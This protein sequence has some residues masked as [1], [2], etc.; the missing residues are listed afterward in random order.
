MNL[1]YFPFTQNTG[2]FNM[3]ADEYLV[4]NKRPSLRLYGWGPPCL[5]LGY[6]QSS[7]DIDHDVLKSNGIEITRRPTGGKAVL[8]WMDLTYSLI[9]PEAY[10][11]GT[12]K[13]S[14]EEIA[15]ILLDFFKTL[16]LEAEIFRQSVP[17]NSSP[18]CFEAAGWFEISVHGKKIIGNAQ[19]RKHGMVL[20]QGTIPYE[21]N[22]ELM[23]KAFRIKE[24]SSATLALRDL[25][26]TDQK[27]EK[28][29]QI[30]HECIKNY[31]DLKE[32]KWEAEELDAIEDIIKKKYALDDWIFHK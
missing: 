23:R 6:H 10:F 8:H 21:V 29:A 11:S 17:R 14:Y 31:F 2:A 27:P 26:S 3:A 1:D 25:S 16:G 7:R 5:S 19:A 24:L 28:G 22:Y 4:I 15:L 20:Q 32:K 9:V 30:F 18:I 12:I 13:Q